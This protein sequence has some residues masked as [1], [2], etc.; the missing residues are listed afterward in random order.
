[1]FWWFVC[2]MVMGVDGWMEV[3]GN[4]DFHGCARRAEFGSSKGL[5]LYEEL[6]RGSFATIRLVKNRYSY[7]RSTQPD[8]ERVGS[9]DIFWSQICLTACL[10]SK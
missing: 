6:T 3:E 8:F 7:A 4:R 5:G 1:M 9:H 10:K 2:W